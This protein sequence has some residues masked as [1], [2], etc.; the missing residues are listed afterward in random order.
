M[1]EV[2]FVSSNE[3]KIEETRA[4]LDGQLITVKPVPLKIEE[5]QTED[6]ALLVRRKAM[7]AFRRVE[8]PLFVEHTSL[9]LDQLNGLPDGLTGVFWEKLE[10]ERFTELFGGG[11]GNDGALA[12]THICYIDGLRFHFFSGETRGRIARRP[13]GDQRFQWDCVFIPEG[14]DCT[15]AELAG[16][17]NEISMRREALNAFAEFL[18]G[19]SRHV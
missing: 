16:T 14:Y 9:C 10:A 5:L 8:R 4:I 7:D 12:R 11:S 3:H 19:Q 2:R 17:K 15:F 13:R 18:N 6:T 1:V